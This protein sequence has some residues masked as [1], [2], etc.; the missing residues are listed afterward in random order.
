MDLLHEMAE[1]IQELRKEINECLIKEEVMWN[2]RSRAI[3]LKN[4]DRNTKFFHATATQRRR[5]NII[6]GLRGPDV[7]WHEDQGRLST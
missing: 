6:D 7:S 1:E 4:G 5:K 3:W 2:Q